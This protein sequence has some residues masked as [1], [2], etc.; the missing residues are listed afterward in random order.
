MDKR[1]VHIEDRRREWSALRFFDPERFAVSICHFFIACFSVIATPAGFDAAV[2]ADPTTIIAG[3]DF[4][5]ASIVA[6]EIPPAAHTGSFVAN[7]TPARSLAG[8]LLPVRVSSV[9]AC[10]PREE[11]P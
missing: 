9:P 10:T 8:P 7:A 4:R 5:T 11:T 6:G 3:F 2:I 1:A